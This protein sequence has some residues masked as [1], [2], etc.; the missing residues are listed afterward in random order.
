MS[1]TTT[2]TAPASAV[3]MRNPKD[4]M[5]STWTDDRSQWNIFHYAI[6]ILG[7]SLGDYNKNAPKHAKTDRM[8]HLGQFYQNRWIFVHAVWPIILHKIY[9]AYT[10][11][12]LSILGAFGL[13][14]IAFK[15]NGVAVIRQM[16]SLSQKHGFLDGDKHDRDGVPDHSVIKV[17]TSLIFTLTL[18]PFMALM[19]AWDADAPIGPSWWLPLEIGLYSVVLDFW[20]YWYH[21]LMHANDG[22]WKFHRTHHLTKHPNPL[23]TLYADGEQEFFDI[24]GIPL[25]TWVSLKAM[26]LP[27]GYYD[28]WMCYQWVVWSELWGHSGIRVHMTTPTPFAPILRFFDAELTVE[29]HDLHHRKGWKKSHNYGK[30]TRLWDRVFGT[31]HERYECL[32]ENIDYEHPI[33]VPMFP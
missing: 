17:L 1:T 29:D 9:V 32:P 26:G 24:V 31:C 6:T 28:W 12:N 5:K 8:P 2:T 18:R 3:P 22:L 25:L 21:R 14:A 16:R 23:L 11:T 10:G 20:F 30:Q 19:F 33:S 7:I 15:L 13:Y 4:S 27:M